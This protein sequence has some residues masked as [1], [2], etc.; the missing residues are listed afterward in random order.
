MT[1]ADLGAA[2]T[3]SVSASA[4]Q[5]RVGPC[6][7][8]GITQRRLQGGP[9]F[10]QRQTQAR[11]VGSQACQRCLA[12]ED[13]R[14]VAGVGGQRFGGGSGRR[15][16]AE[17]VTKKMQERFASLEDEAKKKAAFEKLT[18]GQVSAFLAD[19]PINLIIVGK[20]DV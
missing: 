14:R 6:G 7:G 13:N 3:S 4:R 2:G 15:F 12:P 19:A 11:L 5:R 1:I 20:K 18:S 9:A 8:T 16:T 17:F 10:R